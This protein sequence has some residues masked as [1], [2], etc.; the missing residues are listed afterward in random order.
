[1]NHQDFQRFLKRIASLFLVPVLFSSAALSAL[2]ALPTKA[3][4]APNITSYQGRLLNANGVP[5]ATASASMI[6]EFYDSLGGGTCLYSNSSSTCAS[7]TSRTV[8]L[9]D[10]LFSEN[11]GDTAAGVP[12]AA[13]PDSVFGANAGVYLQITVNGEVLTPRKQFVAAPYA[14]N[15]DTLDGLDSSSFTSLFT[16]GGATT[17]LTDLADDFAVGGTSPTASPF[18]VDESAN[19]VYIGEG[20]GSSGTLVFKAS[21]GDTAQLTINTSDTIVFSGGNVTVTDDFA[22]NGGDLTSSVVTFNIFDAVGNPTNI[23][24]GGVSTDIA[25]TVSI[26]TDSASADT[27]T[28]GSVHASSVLNLRGATSDITGTSVLNLNDSSGTK[29]T[30]IGGV[31]ISGTDTINIATNSSAADTI[32]IGNSNA[33]TTLTLTGG[34]DWSITAGGTATFASLTGGAGAFT[35]LTAGS[36]DNAAGGDLSIGNTSSTSV[37]ICTSA[38]C[39]IISLGTGIDADAIN[40]GGAGDSL[41]L[42]GNVDVVLTTTAN[43]TDNFSIAH[44][45]ALDFSNSSF[46]VNYTDTAAAST[47]TNYLAQLF[48]ANDGGATGTPD[49]FLLIEHAD[50]NETVAYGILME[51]SSAL[52]TALDV[53]DSDIVTALSVGANDILG[54]TATIN[55]TNFDVDTAGNITVAAGTGLDTNAAGTLNIGNVNA[56]TVS[57]CGSAACDTLNLAQGTDADAINL[58]TDATSGDAINMGNSNAGTTFDITGGNR[59]VLDSASAVY[60]N[61]GAGTRTVNIGGVL[62]DGTSTV[63][64]ATNATSADTITIGNSNAGTT[65]AITGGDDWSIA[66]SGLI[67]TASDLAVNGGNL[68]STNS[69]FNFLDATGNSTSI[70][71][72]GVSTDLSN[73]VRIATEGT[74]SDNIF[75][76]N[77]HASTTLDLYGGNNVRIQ[78]GTIYLGETTTNSDI[79]AGSLADNVMNIDFATEGTQADTLDFGNTNA[80]TTMRL[81][82]GDDWSIDTTGDATFEDLTIDMNG[83]ATTNGVC[84]SGTDEDV[85]ASARDLVVC[86]AAPDDYA[87]WYET[88][89]GVGFGDV[90]ATSGSSFT[91]NAKQS[92]PFT[93]MILPG[94]VSK[95]LP[96]MKKATSSDVVFGIVSTSPYQVIGSDVK[97]QG[98]NPMPIA[99]AGRVP[100]HV[101]SEG[102]PIQVGDYLVPSSTPGYAMKA[103]EAGRVIAR[104]LADFSGTGMTTI[105]VFVDNGWYGGDMLAADGS[106]MLTGGITISALANASAGAPTSNSNSLVLNGSAWDGTSAET[107]SM[108][109]RTKVSSLGDYRL[110]IE[111]GTGG[112]VAAFSNA[113]DLFVAGKLFPSDRGSAQSAAYIFYDSTAG[114]GYMKTNA[115]GWN[116]GSYDFAEMFPSSD[117]LVAGDVVVFGGS[118]QSVA[119][120]SSTTYDKGIAGVVSTRPGFL[121][122]EYV[123]G[124]YPI[125]LAGRVPTHVSA[126]N[127]AVAIGD[128]LTSSSKPGYAMKATKAGPILGYAMEPLSAG[129]GKIVA[130]IRASYYAGTGTNAAPDANTAISQLPSSSLSNLDVTGSL[131]MN[132]G[133]ML[134]IGSMEGIGSS[135]KIN[136]NGDFETNGTISERVLSYQNEFVKTFVTTSREK[137][138]QLSGT[139]TLQ[140]GQSEVNFE[141]IDPKFNDIISNVAS[142]RVIVTPAGVTG[143]VY[144]TDKSNSGFYIHD[145]LN[146]NGVAVDWLVIAYQKDFEPAASVPVAAA[147]VPEP[148]PVPVV[149]ADPVV[150]E[151]IADNGPVVAPDV[152]VV[153]PE[154]TPEVAGVTGAPVD[155]PLPPSPEPVIIDPVVTP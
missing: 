48:N 107:V 38:A 31:T 52:T 55:F 9:T 122:G 147:P 83:T 62:S 2:F 99:L 88:E 101:S 77:M 124:S 90:V 22:I 49:G 76:G 36:L 17:Y 47:G 86:S 44:T 115:A 108:G 26:A 96:I 123:S 135:W 143:Q 149:T 150:S 63:A 91:Y 20:S 120:S 145:S 89:A 70:D 14:M 81:R 57:I 84:H 8:T 3:A 53:S 100:L 137:T 104:S 105:L 56:T 142:Y 6:F 75:I 5:I 132:G 112:E 131:N 25:N 1:M 18:G 54:T 10:G 128:P 134:S 117:S 16:D 58:A 79:T 13:I 129:E 23:D 29:T 21:D 73:T 98:A 68:T 152:A 46:R 93:G 12:Y 119:R 24:I 28:I 32:T 37:S 4:S 126:E 33:A 30:D 116:V 69:S 153:T 50:T 103:T 78:G 102:G 92:D 154:P 111:D 136:Q 118:A 43:F 94:T 7:A 42:T 15:A 27:V 74:S 155:E 64:I 121:A 127:G 35:S 140:L 109:L 41:T 151:V 85:S 11:L 138:I 130:F 60:V 34:D 110:S 71:I 40:I 144:V 114:P 19:T 82:G 148:T 51:A 113:G 125:A 141:S 72:G 39:D 95:T 61:D 133:A 67:T 106:S 65:V 87:E 139:A 45:N 146:T 80:A 59:I 97:N 66:S